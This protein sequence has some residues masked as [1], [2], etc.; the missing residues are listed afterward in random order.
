MKKLHATPFLDAAEQPLLFDEKRAAVYL[1]V[2]LSYLR[3][4]RSEGSPA[5]R[6]PAPVFVNIGKRVLYRLRD[7]NA[8]VDSLET[9]RVC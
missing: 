7:L 9:R 3:K 1:G 5:G 2:S 6:T 8:W 4:S